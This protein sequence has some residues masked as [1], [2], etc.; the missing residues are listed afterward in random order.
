MN[1]Q[2]FVDLL[3][4]EPVDT[5]RALAIYDQLFPGKRLPDVDFEAFWKLYP[6]RNGRKIGKK[7]AIEQWNKLDP[8]SQ[9]KVLEAVS[10]YSEH[11]A[12]T[13]RP[14][15]DAFRW[16]RD[17]NWLDFASDAD[18]GSE[19]PR[20]DT[21]LK[22]SDVERIRAKIERDER[23]RTNGYGNQQSNAGIRR[24]KIEDSRGL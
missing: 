12:G 2:D 24:L 11:L 22:M 13:D 10:A 16:I 17:Q 23:M 21:S 20:L 1:Q 14:A 8:D 5:Q 6:A 18:Y 4:A 15:K 19:D 9:T 7:Q 3:L